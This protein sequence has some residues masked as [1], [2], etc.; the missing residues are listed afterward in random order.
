[1]EVEWSILEWILKACSHKNV[2]IEMGQASWR[3]V[4]PST[5]QNISLLDWIIPLRSKPSATA[6]HRL[7]SAWHARMHSKEGGKPPSY[8][9]V[10]TNDRSITREKRPT[11]ELPLQM[12]DQLLTREQGIR[13]E[14]DV[15]ANTSHPKAPH[16]WE[17]EKCIP[18]MDK[19]PKY[20]IISTR[21]GTHTIYEWACS[22]W[23]ISGLM[24]I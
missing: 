4:N 14:M 9:N 24:A 1:M 20:I 3:E 5:A 13:E 21:V 2:V 8:N 12:C 18:Q 11:F 17:P 15:E 16:E 6:R 22:H 10:T 7:S 19:M 23:Q